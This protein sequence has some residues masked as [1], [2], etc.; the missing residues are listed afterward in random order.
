YYISFVII[1]SI[2]ISMVLF[3]G[4]L[5]LK[6][7][8]RA[9][10][11]SVVIVVGL[12]TVGVGKD[13]LNTWNREAD[14][15]HLESYRKGLTV[16]RSAVHADQEYK[17]SFDIIKYLPSRLTTFL[18]A[19]FPWQ[20]ANARVVASFIEMPFWWVLF[21][22]VLSGLMFMLRHKNVREFIP[23]IVYTLM[24]TL[25]YAIVQGNL[26]TA[27]R[28]RAQVLPFFLMMASVG[29][30]VRTAKNLKIDPS[31]ILKKEMR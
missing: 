25:L 2:L 8:L 11:V 17:S 28:M 14:V 29:V 4:E 30:S 31:M 7:I 27:Y 26:G 24:L 13:M 21:P 3:A 15:K 23:L 20:L 12:M 1:G 6:R 16:D 9:V 10:M 22:F 18:F 19:P 5:S